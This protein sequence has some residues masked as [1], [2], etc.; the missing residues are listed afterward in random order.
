M[1]VRA[2]FPITFYGDHLTRVVSDA[3][4]IFEKLSSFKKRFEMAIL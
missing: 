4:H 3:Q 2:Q 1:C